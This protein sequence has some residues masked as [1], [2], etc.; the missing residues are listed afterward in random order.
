MG[1]T[2]PKLVEK[3]PDYPGIRI[4]GQDYRGIT[5]YQLLASRICDFRIIIMWQKSVC[6]SVVRCVQYGIP[7]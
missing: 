7:P 2:G 1:N 3:C 4:S 6:E 5:V